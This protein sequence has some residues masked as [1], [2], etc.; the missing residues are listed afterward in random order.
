MRVLSLPA[1]NTLMAELAQD[2][3]K[4]HGAQLLQI[5]FEEVLPK[6]G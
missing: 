3:S 1:T 2:W 4:P 5:L 6:I